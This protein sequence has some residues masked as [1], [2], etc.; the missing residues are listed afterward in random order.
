[1]KVI[2]FH[3]ISMRMFPGGRQ[4]GLWEGG[5][6]R[7]AGLRALRLGETDLPSING[8]V[9][10]CRILGD[11]VTCKARWEWGRVWGMEP[12]QDPCFQV[13][14]LGPA[15]DGPRRLNFSFIQRETQ[16]DRLQ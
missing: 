6:L 10:P 13:P 14:P 12:R 2:T 9:R 11:L 5:E 7:N 4:T 16:T 3:L 8:P 1:M 15:G